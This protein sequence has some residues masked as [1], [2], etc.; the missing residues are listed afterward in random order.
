MTG[1]MQAS[2]TLRWGRH[3]VPS[4]MAPRFSLAGVTLESLEHSLNRWASVPTHPSTPTFNQST[5][6]AIFSGDEMATQR[7]LA[8]AQRWAAGHQAGPLRQHPPQTTGPRSW[9]A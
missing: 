7:L 8:T 6:T 3:G 2:A 4:H 5:T 9:L 1:G